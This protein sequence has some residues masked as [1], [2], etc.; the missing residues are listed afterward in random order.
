MKATEVNGGWHPSFEF[1]G[2]EKPMRIQRKI[3]QAIALSLAILI[4]AGTAPLAAAEVATAANI[5]SVSAVG[6]VQLRGVGI[7]E[8]TLFSGDSLKVAPEAYAKVVL[9]EGH[10]VELDGNSNVTI[11][12]DAG[13]IN[14]QMT[15]GNIGITGGQKP[16]RVRVGG[17]EITTNGQARGTVA[18]VGSEAFGVRAIDG[19]VSVRNTAT[20]QSFTVVKGTTRL[21][22]LRDSNPAGVL[23]AS[24]MP[25]AIPAPPMVPAARQLSGGAKKALI[26]ASVL[27]T[28][29][30]IAILMSKNDDSDSE[31]SARLARTQALANAAAIEATAAEVQSTSAAIAS[32]TTSALAIINANATI[33]TPANAAAKAALVA[34]A[35][36]TISKANTAAN[37]AISL[38]AQINQLEANIEAAGTITQAQQDQLDS[39]LA[40][41]EAARKAAN[42]ALAALDKL[43]NDANNLAGGT[44]IQDPNIDP[45][46]EPDVS[47]PSNP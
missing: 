29:A 7:S 21:I 23:V 43:I 44:I 34:S 27:G 11:S 41:L 2:R 20:K 33:N 31:A 32:A 30:G 13:I 35:N 37:T 3:T 12:K 25:T 26:V 19:T 24:T 8:G 38:Q 5:G 15:A 47:S 16:V 22:S 28:A 36:A 39:L 4:G 10:K 6:S 42:E 9:V 1:S 17:F 46:D 45:V 18:F 40:Q 14:I